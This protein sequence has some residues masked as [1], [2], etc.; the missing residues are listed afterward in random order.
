MFAHR[1]SQSMSYSLYSSIK[2][3]F[4]NFIIF[5]LSWKQFLFPFLIPIPLYFSVSVLLWHT[6]KL[7]FIDPNPTWWRMKLSLQRTKTRL[8]RETSIQVKDSLTY[9]LI[10]QSQQL[11]ALWNTEVI[12]QYRKEEKM[13]EILKWLLKIYYDIWLCHLYMSKTQLRIRLI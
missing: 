6:S 3:H 2:I 13:R 11:P 10:F 9:L 4:Y 7:R 8:R 12:L 5:P 1:F